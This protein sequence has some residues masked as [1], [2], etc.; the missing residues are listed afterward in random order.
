LKYDDNGTLNQEWSIGTRF[1]E[2]WP[3]PSPRSRAMLVE[4]SSTGFFYISLGASSWVI[5][6]QAYV[7]GNYTLPNTDLLSSTTM[8]ILA[9]GG[10]LG[11]ATL[12]GIVLYRKRDT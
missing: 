7:I 2:G 1:N 10:A 5:L 3:A 12:S 9:L 11:V 6:T 8:V 4:V